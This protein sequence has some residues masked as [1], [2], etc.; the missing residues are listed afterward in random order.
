MK[1]GN[2]TIS[3][4]DSILSSGV[5]VQQRVFLRGQMAFPRRAAHVRTPEILP[6]LRDRE[7]IGPGGSSLSAGGDAQ[8]YGGKEI[9]GETLKL[10]GSA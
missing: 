10:G 6:L 4:R 5:G 9:P 8:R 7:A 2:K 3:E 1:P